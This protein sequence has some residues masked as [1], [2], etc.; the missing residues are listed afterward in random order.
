MMRALHGDVRNTASVKQ[1][2][3]RERVQLQ[4]QY[5]FHAEIKRTSACD[6]YKGRRW[7]V[8]LLTIKEH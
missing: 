1:V 2:L 7:G 8:H 6:A 4:V 3:K 5:A